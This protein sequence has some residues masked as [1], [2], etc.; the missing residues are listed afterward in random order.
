MTNY[1]KVY[2][3]PRDKSW[4]RADVKTSKEVKDILQEAQRRGYERYLVIKRIKQKTD[5]PIAHGF[6]SK[7]CKVVEVEGLDTDWRVVG[8][9]VVDYKKYKEEEER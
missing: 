6:F 4:K 9:N 3:K 8:A 1:F 5:V 7:E 2:L